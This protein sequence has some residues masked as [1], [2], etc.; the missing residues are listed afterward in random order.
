M[1]SSMSSGV[2]LKQGHGSMA[3]IG[4]IVEGRSSNNDVRRVE[5]RTPIAVVAETEGARTQV[6]E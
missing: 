1:R 6:C 3:D 5:A 4:G 2:T